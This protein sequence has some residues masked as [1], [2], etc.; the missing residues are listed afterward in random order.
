MRHP[1]PHW[2]LVHPMVF[3]FVLV[4]GV[5]YLY[6]HFD[7]R[8]LRREREQSELNQ[9]LDRIEQAIDAIA[10]QVEVIRDRT[11]PGPR[12]LLPDERAP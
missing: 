10:T 9:R 12:G 1:L 6:S 8:L 11:E 3:S 7:G 5:L 2:H 4:I